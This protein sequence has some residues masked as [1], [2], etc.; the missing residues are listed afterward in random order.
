MPSE[1][2]Y[3][4]CT[5]AAVT[6]LRCPKPVSGRFFSGRAYAEIRFRQGRPQSRLLRFVVIEVGR[7]A[8]PGTVVARAA[9]GCAEGWPSAAHRTRSINARPRPEQHPHP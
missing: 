4:E 7:K 1:L 5:V 6:R 2:P 9:A 3:E 8:R